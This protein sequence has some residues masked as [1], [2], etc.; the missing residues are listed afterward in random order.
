[1][2]DKDCKRIMFRE[3]GE[4]MGIEQYFMTILSVS[5]DEKPPHISYLDSELLQWPKIWPHEYVIMPHFRKSV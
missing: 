3:H 4:G 5:M 2:M 1:M